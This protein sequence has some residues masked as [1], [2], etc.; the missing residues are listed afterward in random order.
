MQNKTHPGKVKVR[1]VVSPH[2]VVRDLQLL[3]GVHVDPRDVAHPPV[4]GL[5]LVRLLALQPGSLG[6]AVRGS[7]QLARLVVLNSGPLELK[8]EEKKRFKILI[9]ETIESIRE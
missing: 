6:D 5:H 9:F 4:D 1:L 2:A 7:L 8:K 3:R